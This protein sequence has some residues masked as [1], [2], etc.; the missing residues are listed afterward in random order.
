MQCMG[1]VIPRCHL[2]SLFFFRGP[3]FL[4]TP[5]DTADGGVLPVAMAPPLGLTPAHVPSQPRGSGSFVSA[6]EGGGP[7][8]FGG[9][10]EGME[11]CIDKCVKRHSPL[12][13]FLLSPGGEGERE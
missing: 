7:G 3:A 12:I 5:F 4:Q 13:H 6:L 11:S 1:G 10:G 8:L 2:L 9:L